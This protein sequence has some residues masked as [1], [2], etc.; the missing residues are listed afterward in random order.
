[1]ITNLLVFVDEKASFLNNSL[2]SRDSASHQSEKNKNGII[3]KND[4]S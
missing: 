1:M 3:L 2:F 4:R